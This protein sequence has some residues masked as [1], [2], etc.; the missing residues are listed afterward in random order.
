MSRRY[1]AEFSSFVTAAKRKFP[2]A[3]ES[4][5][6][7]FDIS[8]WKVLQ[9]VVSP[10]GDEAFT[11]DSWNIFQRYGHCVIYTNFVWNVGGNVGEA[12]LSRARRSK[13]VYLLHGGDTLL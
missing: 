8:I 13:G 12:V 6:N 10:Q 7:P 11:T 3:S 5:F 2:A 9:E 4:S 1:D